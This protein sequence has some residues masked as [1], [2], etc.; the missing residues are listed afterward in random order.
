METPEATAALTEWLR[1]AFQQLPPQ[2][3]DLASLGMSH[4]NVPQLSKSALLQLQETFLK[5]WGQY[6]P[7]VY[8]TFSS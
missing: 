4:G 5:E 1:P 3:G 2:H 8:P 6:L 7:G